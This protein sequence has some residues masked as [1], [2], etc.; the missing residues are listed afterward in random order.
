MQKP[1]I[2]GIG[3]VNF[4]RFKPFSWVF[5]YI[6]WKITLNNTPAFEHLVIPRMFRQLNAFLPLQL[7]KR[8]SKSEKSLSFSGLF[9]PHLP[10]RRVEPND[11][12]IL[13]GLNEAACGGRLSPVI[14]GEGQDEPRREFK[15]S[16]GWGSRRTLPL[17]KTQV[18]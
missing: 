17:R 16:V 14:D 3:N 9:F 4:L 18:D 11:L 1:F 2:G 12:D 8:K 6:Q 10:D 15:T 5:Y 7:R 13:G